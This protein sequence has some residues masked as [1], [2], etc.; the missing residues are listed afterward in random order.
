MLTQRENH[1][2]FM[3]LALEEASLSSRNN[4]VPIGAILVVNNVVVSR[5]H[6]MTESWNDPTAHAE[7]IAI[8]D[9]SRRLKRWRLSDAAL[10]VTVEPCAMCAWA[11]V[12]ARI[13][14]LVYGCTDP[15]AGA[16]GSLYDIIGDSKVANSI[17]TSSGIL[18]I[19]CKKLLQDFFNRL[20]SEKMSN[21]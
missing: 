5:A 18:E 3:R 4:E 17:K 16:A 7:I 9:A 10:Y 8:K 1:I 21:S 19:E 12:L 14:S 13:S 15:R 11:I 20:R 6:N 2:K